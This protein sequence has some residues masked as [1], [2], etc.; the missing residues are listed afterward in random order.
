MPSLVKYNSYRTGPLNNKLNEFTRSERIIS[1]S[2][3]LKPHR[4]QGGSGRTTP[5]PSGAEMSPFPDCSSHWRR[6]LLE[7]G[8]WRRDRDAEGVEG[9]EWRGVSPS[10]ADQGVWGSVVSSPGGVR[11][12]AP[13]ENGFGAF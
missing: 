13:A 11:G 8:G 12:G 1:H 2:C 3:L 6:Y 4:I 10:P 7:E 9:G 5:P